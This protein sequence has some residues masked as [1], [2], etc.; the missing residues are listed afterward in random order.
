MH[1]CWAHENDEALV[2]VLYTAQHTHVSRKDEEK[3]YN[4]KWNAI[5]IKRAVEYKF[6]VGNSDDSRAD[7]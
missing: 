3:K 6:H 7:I 2:S 5:K 1:F 4:N